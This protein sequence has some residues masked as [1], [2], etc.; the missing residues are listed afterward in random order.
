M[1]QEVTDRHIVKEA[2]RRILWIVMGV[3][4]TGEAFE[5]NGFRHPEAQ[6]TSAIKMTLK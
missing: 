2:S 4:K 3:G 1:W 6:T 5:A